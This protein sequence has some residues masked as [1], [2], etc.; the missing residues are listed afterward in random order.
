[1]LRAHNMVVLQIIYTDVIFTVVNR[2]SMLRAH[3]MVL[4]IMSTNVILTVVN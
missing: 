3:N 2:V 4:K 1:M